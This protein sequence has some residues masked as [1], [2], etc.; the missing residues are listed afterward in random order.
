MRY[1]AGTGGHR[2]RP[3]QRQDKPGFVE[4]LIAAGTLDIA[5]PRRD[6]AA[7]MRGVS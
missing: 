1:R 5:H 6:L 3:A 7:L 2:P 4:L